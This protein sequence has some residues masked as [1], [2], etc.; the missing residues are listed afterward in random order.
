[1]MRS[2]K[3]QLI[4]THCFKKRYQKLTN[5]NRKLKK[6][7]V[8]LLKMLT[9]DPFSTMLSTHKIYSRQLGQRYSSRITGDIRII[10]DFDSGLKNGIVLLDLGGH[11]G[12]KKVY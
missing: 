9:L 1:M 12:K 10:W 3:Y 8:N 4:T 2:S 5:N 11:E 6:R 7:I